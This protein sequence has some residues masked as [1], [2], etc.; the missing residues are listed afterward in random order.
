MT[1]TNGALVL[2]SGGQDSTTCLA[3]ALA[4]YAKV[5]TIGF[6]YGQRHAVELAVRPAILQKMRTLAPGWGDKLG[7]DHMIDLSL[8]SKISHTAL[9]QDVEIAMQDNGLPNTFVP[10]RNLLFM[11]VAATVAY[12]RGLDVLVGG[13]CET[14]FSGYP[15]CRDD[16]MKALQVALNLGMATRLKLET[17]LMWIDKAQTWEL[18]RSLGGTALVDV[19]RADTHTCYLGERGALHDWGYGCG[20]CPACELRANGYRVFSQQ[21]KA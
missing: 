14:D 16:T 13:M 9:T 20:K 21:E 18:A 17:P 3:W 11:T 10:G 8:I 1:M 5:E 15:D 4:R 6:D 12:R 2:F 19:I 7:E